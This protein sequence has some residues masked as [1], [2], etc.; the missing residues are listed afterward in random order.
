MAGVAQGVPLLRPGMMEGQLLLLCAI[1]SEWLSGVLASSACVAWG[2]GACLLPSAPA[3]AGCSR[4]P[5]LQPWLAPH[6][7]DQRRKYMDAIGTMTG[8]VCAL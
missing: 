6:C 3:S 5:Q 1:G 4:R 7:Q 2:Q 8:Y